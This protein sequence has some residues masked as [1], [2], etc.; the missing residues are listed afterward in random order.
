MPGPMGHL[1]SLWEGCEPW[2]FAPAP[3]V[4]VHICHQVPRGHVNLRHHAVIVAN[5]YDT[6]HAS[7]RTLKRRPCVDEVCT[8]VTS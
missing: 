2:A 5:C 3:I 7:R 1:D 6:L 8:T 4:L